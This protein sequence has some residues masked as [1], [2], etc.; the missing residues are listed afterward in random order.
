MY[1]QDRC[2]TLKLRAQKISHLFQTHYMYTTQ[3][4]SSVLVRNT[5]CSGSCTVIKLILGV[6]G[7]IVVGGGFPP[8]SRSANFFL[9]RLHCATVNVGKPAYKNPAYTGLWNVGFAT[10]HSCIAQRTFYYGM[11]AILYIN[12]KCPR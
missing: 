7:P 10:K 2:E 11:H 4:A 3:D 1:Q 9:S 8:R 12:M 5:R 6:R